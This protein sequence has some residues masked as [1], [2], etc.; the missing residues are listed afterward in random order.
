MFFI[1]QKT[2]SHIDY[3]GETPRQRYSVSRKQGCTAR[4]K[5]EA[6]GLHVRKI[7][8]RVLAVMECTSMY[9]FHRFLNWPEFA[10]IIPTRNYK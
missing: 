5:A 9:P 7:L 8:P 3:N 2:P 4:M 6:Q 1:M 10:I